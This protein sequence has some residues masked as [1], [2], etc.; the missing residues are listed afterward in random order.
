METSRVC[1]LPVRVS[2]N[3]SAYGGYTLA[4]LRWLIAG[5]I[6]AIAL[7]KERLET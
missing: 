6:V 2:S 4:S 3:R 7:K 5:C 1:A